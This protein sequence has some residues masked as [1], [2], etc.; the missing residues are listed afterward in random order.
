VNV[1]I[2]SPLHRTK[3]C[4]FPL[5]FG[6]ASRYSRCRSELNRV[7]EWISKAGDIATRVIGE[8]WWF[9]PA[10]L[11]TLILSVCRIVGKAG[12]AEEASVILLIRREASYVWMV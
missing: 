11:V 3:G 7:R 10:A 8:R 12:D 1:C 5:A 6:A 2:Y 9:L 4:A